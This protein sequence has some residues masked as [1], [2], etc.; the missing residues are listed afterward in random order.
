M[1][2]TRITGQIKDNSNC[3]AKVAK[4]IRAATSDVDRPDTLSSNRERKSMVEGVGGKEGRRQGTNDCASATTGEKW[5][6]DFGL[7]LKYT[8]PSLLTLRHAAACCA[9]VSPCRSLILIP[10]RK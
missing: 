1:N 10:N 6:E 9:V 7:A 3:S 5:P 4:A 2:P 8:D